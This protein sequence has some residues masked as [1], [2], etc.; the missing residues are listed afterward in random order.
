MKLIGK[1]LGGLA[2]AAALAALIPYASEYDE[3]SDT[4]S[5][6]ALLWSLKSQP[7]EDGKRLYEFTLGKPESCNC[8]L[9]RPDAEDAV[10]EAE[11]AAAEADKSQA[12]ADAAQAAADRKAE[13]AEAAMDAAE[14]AQDPSEED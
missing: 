12:E 11:E 14:A 6:R 4:R 8:P 1:V 10:A 13:A 5:T 9:C 7:G 3:S 2:T